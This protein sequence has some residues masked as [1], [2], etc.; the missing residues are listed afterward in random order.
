MNLYLHFITT[1]NIRYTCRLGKPGT[2][3]KEGPMNLKYP[4]VFYAFLKKYLKR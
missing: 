4:P 3:K 2:T 1:E